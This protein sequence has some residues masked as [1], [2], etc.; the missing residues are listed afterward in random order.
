MPYIS[1]SPP[2]SLFSVHSQLILV[3]VLILINDFSHRDTELY[4]LME[5]ELDSLSEMLLVSVKAGRSAASYY[6]QISVFC[7]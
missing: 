4:Y 2:P 6:V 7:L 3:S 5:R 1:M